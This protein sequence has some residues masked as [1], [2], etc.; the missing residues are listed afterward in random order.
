MRQAITIIAFLLAVGELSAAE[1]Q[2][3][4]EVRTTG[5]LVLVSDIAEIHAKDSAEAAELA[6]IDLMP[7]PPYGEKR[8]LR[9]REV[10]DLLAVRGVN[11]GSHRFSGASQVTIQGPHREPQPATRKLKAPPAVRKI[12]TQPIEEATR[13]AIEGYLNETAGKLG[14]L[15]AF[16][17]SEQRAREI[18]ALGDSLEVG[19]GSA[20]W[21]GKQRFLVSADNVDASPI[22]VTVEISLPP[23]MVVAQ[24]S[25]PKGTILRAGDVKLQRGLPTKGEAEVYQSIDDV[26]GK[27][28]TRTVAEGQIL[29][30]R[31]V[32]RQLLVRRN[33]VVT[34]YSR[35]AG[36][37]VRVTARARDDGA[38]GDVV[39]VE[40]LDDRKPMFARVSG[41]Q[42]VEVFAQALSAAMPNQHATQ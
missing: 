31:T 2:L 1:L 4:S 42:E 18:A 10:Q 26:V 35:A 7:A 36:V 34:L 6:A 33:E 24:H 30:S 9:L 25:L 23:A 38:A 8:T 29:D 17:L 39:T 37:S 21:T 11:L 14:W 16:D 20:P 15:I 41:P 28:T 5:P 13:S 12:N 32:R 27:E 19:G 40:T 22:A 3:H